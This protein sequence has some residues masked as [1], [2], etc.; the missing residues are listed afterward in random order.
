M[1]KNITTIGGKHK[2][3]QKLVRKIKSKKNLTFLIKIYNQDNK[4]TKEYIKITE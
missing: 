4:W 2:N 1:S 3:I